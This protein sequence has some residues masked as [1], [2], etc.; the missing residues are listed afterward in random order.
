[1]IRPSRAPR[2]RRAAGG[3]VAFVVVLVGALSGAMCA[4]CSGPR[5]DADSR[6]RQVLDDARQRQE[7]M[8]EAERLT[9]EGDALIEKN[10]DGAIERYRSAI[11]VWPRSPIAYNN[12]GYAL[13]EQGD[14]RGA[15][16]ALLIAAEQLPTDARPLQNLG[17]LYLRLGWNEEAY[18]RFAEALG[19]DPNHV[20]SL[21]GIAQAAQALQRADERTLE[22]VKRAQL[23]VGESNDWG[24]YLA[25]QRLRIEQQLQNGG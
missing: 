11:R 6:A 24:P 17:L 18:E 9:A 22:F 7:A 8:L 14:Y 13:L 12:L 2:A 15:S 4:G 23:F 3:L 16:E 5:S 21:T 19:R 1:M 10:L 20:P 25:R